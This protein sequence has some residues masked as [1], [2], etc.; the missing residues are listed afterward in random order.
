M[1]KMDIIQIS[2]SP[3]AFPLHMVPKSNGG[4]C[5]CGDYCRLNDATV[6]DRDPI[7]HI[8]DF[9]ACL[10][11]TNIFSKI[12]LVR[13]YHQIPVAPK[14]VPKTAVITPF[15]IFVHAIQFEMRSTIVSTPYGHSTSGPRLCICLPRRYFGSQLLSPVSYRRP[16][17]C[18]H[19]RHRGLI[20]KLE[21]CLF[22][23]SSLDFWGHQVNMAGSVLMPSRISAVKDFPQPRDVKA[24]QEFLGIMNFYHRFIPNLASILRPLYQVINTSV[25]EL[26]WFGF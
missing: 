14:D 13:G 7:P 4:L 20:I 15:G 17:R 3:W 16:Q 12:K 2:N 1:E 19:R 9:S 25:R 11:G 6:P 18:F 8:Q 23:V 21:K 24:L 5:P 22:G 10:A 26:F